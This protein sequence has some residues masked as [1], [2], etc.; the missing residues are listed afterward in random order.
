MHFWNP[1][2]KTNNLTLFSE[3]SVHISIMD[4]YGCGTLKV[5]GGHLGN[6]TICDISENV[7]QAFIKLSAKSHNLN[8]LCTMGVLSC[9]TI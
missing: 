2:D 8:I 9:P 1:Y 4:P 6:A 7:V 5:N 3:K